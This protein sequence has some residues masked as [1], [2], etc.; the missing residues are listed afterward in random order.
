MRPIRALHLVHE[1]CRLSIM[2][3]KVAVVK[4]LVWEKMV[5][6]PAEMLRRLTKLKMFMEP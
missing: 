5:N 6:I 2:V 3:E 4:I 1:Y